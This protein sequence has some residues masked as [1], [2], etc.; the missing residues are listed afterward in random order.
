[1]CGDVADPKVELV[2]LPV[3]FERFH[4]RRFLN[5]Q[6]NRAHA[7]GWADGDELRDAAARTRSP[8]E[9]VAVFED[10][11]AEAATEGRLSSL[12]RDRRRRWSAIAASALCLTSRSPVAV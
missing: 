6:F 7:L 2:G 8:Q 4:R 9:C 12:R 11:S 5:Y 3:G 10:L 1:V